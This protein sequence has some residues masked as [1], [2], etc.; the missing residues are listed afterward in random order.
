MEWCLDCHRNPAAESAAARRDFQHP[1]ASAAR[2]GRA[3]PRTGQGSTTLRI[4]VTSPPARC[5]IDE[6]RKDLSPEL[7]DAVGDVWKRA[8]GKKYWRT[9]GRAGRHAGL[10]GA[11]AAGVSRAGGRTG[12]MPLSRRQFLTLM[13]ASLALAG[14]S[15]LLRAA[16]AAITLRA[17]C[18]GARRNRAGPAVVLCHRHDAR[19]QRR[20]PAGREPSGPA[21]Q[22][23]GQPRPSR[24]PAAPPTLFHQASVLT[25][26]DPD[27][28]QDRHLPRPDAHLGRRPARHCGRAC[29]AA[30]KRR[31]G[32]AACDRNRRLAH[33]GQQITASSQGVSRRR[34]GINTNRSPATTAHRAADRRLRR[35]GLHSMLHD[36]TQS[37]RGRVP[38]RR[39]PRHAAPAVVRYVADFM[40]AAARADHGEANAAQA[41]MNRLYVVE[42]ARDQHRGQGRPSPGLRPATLTRLRGRWPRSLA[43]STAAAGR[44]AD[45][46]AHWRGSIA[47]DLRQPTVGQQLDG[48]RGTTLVMAGDR[49][50]PRPSAGPRDQSTISATSARPDPHRSARSPGRSIK[51]RRCEELAEGY[52]GGP[53]SRCCVILGGNPVYNAPADFQLHRTHAE[54]AASRSSRPLP[55]RNLACSATGT[56][57]KRIIS[58]PGAT[59]AAT[60]ARRRSSSR[61]SSRS[62]RAGRP[63]NCSAAL[64]AAARRRRLELVRGPI[65]QSNW[66]VPRVSAGRLRGLLADGASMTASW[67]APRCRRNA[68]T[69]KAGWEKQLAAAGR[70]RR[71]RAIE[72]TLQPDPTIYDGRFANNGWLQE[73]PKPITRTHLGQ[74]RYHESG[75]PRRNWASGWAVTPTAANTAAIISRLCR[76]AARRA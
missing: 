31:G 47:D 13:G 21:D 10:P 67:P 66:E 15:R 56:C 75:R 7:A 33:A 2:S 26:Y 20:R 22:D 38:R 27:R 39:L 48:R 11:D 68:V 42:T 14:L 24:Q 12:P 49:Q 45:E 61:S 72:L 34:N 71:R 70:R 53:A 30:R 64:T 65:G 41:H 18:P 57:R 28:S 40:A 74:R 3:R 25:L 4:P 55:G 37:R 36:F 50:P 1:M 76:A 59:R 62:T 46:A 29:A 69:C 51:P 44:S 19:R 54:G 43:Y 35:T 58:K 9:P 63:T 32:L 52:G 8:Q 6:S 60:T 17:L 73:L 5:A 23:R 16:G